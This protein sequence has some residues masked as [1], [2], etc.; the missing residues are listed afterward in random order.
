[1]RR[2]LRWTN[3]AIAAVTLASALAVLVSDLGVPGYREHYRDALWFVTLYA[4]AQAVVLAG[5]AR[6]GWWV[7]WLAL[8][9]TGAAYLFLANFV[10]LWPAWRTWTPGRYV[11]DLFD[12]SADTPIGLFALVLLGRGAFNTVNAFVLTQAW[13]APLRLRRPLVGRLV[14][15]VPIAVSV[16]CVWLFLGLVRE[17]AKTFSPEAHE[18]ARRVLAGLD[19]AAVRAN[20]GKTT[21]D[22]RQGGERR[23]H[24]QI[25][26]DCVLTRVLV[27]TEDGRVGTAAMP[28]VACCSSA[29]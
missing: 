1:M 27:S 2:V 26:Y 8:A 24:V 4:A 16:V 6:D 14:T 5:F 20:L 22:L 12:W 21:T 23:Y 10:V 9:K 17:E 25:T 19:C 7:P 15:A 29:P 11:Y 3:V 28:E 18:V 13:W